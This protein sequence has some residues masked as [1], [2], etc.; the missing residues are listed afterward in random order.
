MTENETFRVVLRYYSKV[1]LTILLKSISSVYK[2]FNFNMGLNKE[3]SWSSLSVFNRT[4]F[5]N[6]GLLIEIL[7]FDL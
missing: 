4:W 5:Q 7:Y 6:E 1:S 3:I 2:C